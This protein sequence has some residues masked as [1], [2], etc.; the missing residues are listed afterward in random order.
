MSDD[1]KLEKLDEQLRTAQRVAKMGFW[2]WNIITGALFWTEEIFSIFGLDSDKFEATYD[3]FLKSVHADD[4]VRVQKAVDAS[5]NHRAEYKIEHRIVRPDGELRYVSE[6]GFVSYSDSGT[7][8]RMLGTVVDITQLKEA[9]LNQLQAEEEFHTLWESNYHP[10]IIIN[11]N[12]EITRVNKSAERVFGYRREQL[13]GADIILLVPEHMRAEHSMHQRRY[14]EKPTSRAMGQGLELEAQCKDGSIIP[15]EISLN[16][17]EHNG[18][19]EIQ[20]EIQDISVRKSLEMKLAQSGKLEALGR[21]FSGLAHD[22]NNLLAAMYSSVELA[23]FKAGHSESMD[24]NL[25]R[26]L[27]AGERAKSMVNQMLAFTRQQPLTPKLVAFNQII[28]DFE[29]IISPLIPD[30]IDLQ[31]DLDES[32]ENIRIDPEKIEQVVMNL[33]VNARDAIEGNGSI[34]IRTRRSNASEIELGSGTDDRP[35]S[36]LQ[37]SVIDTGSGMT[38]QQRANIFEPFY[39]TKKTGEGTGLGL[40]SVYGL[41][42]QSRGEILVHSNPGE[43]SAFHI[44][45]PLAETRADL[46]D[47]ASSRRLDPTSPVDSVH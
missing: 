25:E 28:Q 30:W 9:E 4:R 24:P 31:L 33:V 7:P 36:W 20:V 8:E 3:A 32:I 26:A 39:T 38:A 14:L 11:S 16:P 21:S 13:I 18:R 5:V 12:N 17:V 35:G 40:S 42:K 19:K 37:V 41:V 2:E 23:A 44:Y 47:T 22:L 29:S 43:G 10:L 34:T 15:V 27:K 6:Q 1:E 45:L 46:P